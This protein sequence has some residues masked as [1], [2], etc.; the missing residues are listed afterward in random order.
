MTKTKQHKKAERARK[1]KQIKKLTRN[2]RYKDEYS[3]WCFEL[4]RDYYICFVTYAFHYTNKAIR[5]NAHL[6]FERHMQRI[7]NAVVSNKNQYEEACILMVYKEEDH[8]GR[9]HY[10]GLLLVHKNRYDR[11]MSKVVERTEEFETK[12][13]VKKDEVN[14]YDRYVIAEKYLKP[15]HQLEPLK[16]NK[17]GEIK[18]KLKEKQNITPILSL[19]DLVLLPAHSDEQIERVYR[20]S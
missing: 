10:H 14:T 20:Y 9:V 11:F 1:R 7:N 13:K 17:Y 5:E 18:F 6:W 16:K 12:S 19:K 3:R 8:N 4:K 15:F 2:E